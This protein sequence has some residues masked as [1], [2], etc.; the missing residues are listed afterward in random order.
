VNLG[1]DTSV[2]LR[3][4]TGQPAELAEIAQRRLEQAHADGDTVVI[5]DLVLAE[6]YYALVHHYQFAK[7]DARSKLH[8]MANSGTV[9]IDPSE[10][11][12]ALNKAHGAGLVDRLILH[13]YRAGQAS[14]LT[15]DKALGAA[16][17]TRLKT[18]S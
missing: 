12:A 17:A 8:H 18:K 14:T 13:R 11:R 6:C 3:L 7:E 4:L 16:G 5:S 2:V 1:L 10:A 15:F 9:V